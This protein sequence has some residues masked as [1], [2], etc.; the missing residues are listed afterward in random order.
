MGVEEPM[1]GALMVSIS[2]GMPIPAS[3]SKKAKEAA[4]WGDLKHTKRPDIDNLMKSILDGM[5]DIVYFDDA[6]IVHLTSYKQY[7]EHPYVNVL[8]QKI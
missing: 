1:Q 3:Y 4:Y 8:V 2:F 5:N 7:A 6:Q